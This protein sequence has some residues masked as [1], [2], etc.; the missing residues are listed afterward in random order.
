MRIPG[1]VDHD[2]SVGCSV[3]QAFLKACR[4]ES[5]RGEL[6]ENLHDPALL[7]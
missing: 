5:P 7:H 6:L 4:R 3:M 1:Q 2:K